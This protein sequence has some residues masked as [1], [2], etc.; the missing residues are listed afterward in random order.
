MLARSRRHIAAG[1]AVWSG[2]GLIRLIEDVHGRKYRMVDS[3]EPSQQAC[4]LLPIKD[5]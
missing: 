2:Q 4:A 1:G 3:R 5:G